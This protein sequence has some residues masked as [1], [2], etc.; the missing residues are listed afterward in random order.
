MNGYP[1]IKTQ[2]LELIF[3]SA[4]KMI[5]TVINDEEILEINI[6]D[7]L[8]FDSIRFIELIVGIENK[9]QVEIDDD[10]LTMANFS[11]IAR[12]IENVTSIMSRYEGEQHE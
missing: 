5:D 9:F 1:N 12:I 8:G 2:I 3:N 11:T 6:F 10:L 7:D 4:D